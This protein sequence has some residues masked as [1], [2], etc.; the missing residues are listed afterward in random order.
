MKDKVSEIIKNF[1][2]KTSDF[3][4]N[5]TEKIKGSYNDY[6]D[7]FNKKID[8][9]KK[10]SIYTNSSAKIAKIIDDMSSKWDDF[11]DSMEIE[12]LLFETI[13]NNIE[14]PKTQKKIRRWPIFI[15][16]SSAIICLSFS[17]ESKQ[18]Y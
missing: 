13:S 9:L 1:T 14:I 4:G 12:S 8:D 6:K 7:S 18:E 2:E 5:T 16:L 15:M 10:N 11:L 17:E 3:I